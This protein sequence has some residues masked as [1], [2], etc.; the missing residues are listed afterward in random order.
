MRCSRGK[1]SARCGPRDV[2]RDALTERN[3]LETTEMDF[4]SRFLEC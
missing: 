4:L 2:G 3:L 1:G